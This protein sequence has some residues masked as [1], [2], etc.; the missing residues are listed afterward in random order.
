[1][2]MTISKVDGLKWNGIET[3]MLMAMGVPL[4]NVKGQSGDK[5][6]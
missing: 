1:M 5:L 6:S 4:E 3:G 2:K